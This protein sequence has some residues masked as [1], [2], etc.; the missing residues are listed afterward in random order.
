MGKTSVTPKRPAT[1][2]TKPDR[3]TLPLSGV[4]I[5]ITP[6]SP[7]TEPAD[8]EPVTFEG[9]T[10]AHAL[11]WVALTCPSLHYFT[12]PQSVSLELMGVAELC[13]AVG[14]AN[15]EMIPSDHNAMWCSVADRL[16]DLAHR[17]HA[18]DPHYKKLDQEMLTI[19]RKAANNGGTAEVK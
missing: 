15:L 17:I 13:R 5:T 7:F 12:N 6:P 4:S 14:D 16:R 1:N 10:L 11:R 9:E 18:G 2:A 19:T 8:I 3:E